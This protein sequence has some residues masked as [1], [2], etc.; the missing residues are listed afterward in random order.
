MKKIKQNDEMK[1]DHAEN[2]LHFFSLSYQFFNQTMT[3]K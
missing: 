3:M 1:T 2:L